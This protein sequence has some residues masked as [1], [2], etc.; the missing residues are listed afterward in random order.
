MTYGPKHLFSS[1]SLLGLAVTEW[2]D[3]GAP[4]MPSN[5]IV[6]ATATI[7]SMVL[8]A[9]SLFKAD[10]TQLLV[11]FDNKMSPDRHVPYVTTRSSR[12]QLIRRWKTRSTLAT[13]GTASNY[14]K[15]RQWTF[16]RV[17]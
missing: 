5:R 17:C 6:Y 9:V 10:F 7:A 4:T 16:T 2:L 11:D 14:L 1:Y 15:K 13:R 12:S 3:L 8:A